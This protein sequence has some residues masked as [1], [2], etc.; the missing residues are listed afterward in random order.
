VWGDWWIRSDV[1]SWALAVPADAQDRITR[2]ADLLFYGDS[3]GLRNPFREEASSNRRVRRR[4][5]PVAPLEAE[6]E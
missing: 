2:G 3:T 4:L 6:V 1:W 5:Q